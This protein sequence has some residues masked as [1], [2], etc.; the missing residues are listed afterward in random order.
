MKEITLKNGVKMP[1]V[2]FGTW[3]SPDNEVTTESV[4]TAL[5]CGY[6]HI[7]GAAAYGN[8][9]WVGKGIRE[10]G[11]PREELFV[12]SKLWNDS[13]GYTETLAAFD[14]TMEDLG[15]DYLDLYLIHWPV[16][17][18][19]KDSYIEKNRGTWRAFEELYKKGKVKAIGVSNFKPHHIEEIAAG[20]E[21]FP[22]V[23]QIEFHPSYLRTEIRKYCKDNGIVVQAYSPLAHG[24]V[25]Q[26]D[27]LKEMADKYQ[28]TVAQ[29]CV[30]YALQHDMAAIVKSVT[31]ERIQKNIQLDFSIDPVDMKNMD[32]ITSCEGW[33]QDSDDIDF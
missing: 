4:K 14:R 19:I 7:D 13:H 15:L 10:S 26:C 21:V 31:K 20:C 16:P 3:K 24:K 33:C 12:T 18:A 11:I 2:G 1:E 22:M 25:F 27:E 5:T 29:L 28:V 23:N 17:A 30:K 8:E 6:R 32:A 9:K